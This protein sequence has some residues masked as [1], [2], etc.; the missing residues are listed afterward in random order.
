MALTCIADTY[1]AQS[2]VYSR[3]LEQ[4]SLG[5]KNMELWSRDVLSQVALL[6]NIIKIADVAVDAT[7]ITLYCAELEELL[8]YQ[9]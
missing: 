5:N 7:A 8:N 2:N 1:T 3:N 4:I 6:V 9:A